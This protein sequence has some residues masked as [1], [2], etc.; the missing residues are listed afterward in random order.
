MFLS[1]QFQQWRIGPIPSSSGVG[2]TVPPSEEWPP[3][4]P[5]DWLPFPVTRDE[6]PF[7]WE[8][9]SSPDGDDGRISEHEA[10]VKAPIRSKNFGNFIS[11]LS[12]RRA[13]E[14][15]GTMVSSSFKGRMNGPHGGG[16]RDATRAILSAMS[17]FLK[18]RLQT[19]HSACPLD[20][21]GKRE[22]GQ[23]LWF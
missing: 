2:V 1:D 11:L 10:R 18:R 15:S 20:A 7:P 9:G 4:W 22:T 8:E 23:H 13:R 17:F 16:R 14:R 3:V 19:G 5:P 6:L 12:F 21:R